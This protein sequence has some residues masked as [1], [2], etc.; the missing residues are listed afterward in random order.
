MEGITERGEAV[1]KRERERERER[2]MKMKNTTLSLLENR[3]VNGMK[4][5]QRLE[6][7]HGRERQRVRTRSGKWPRITHFKEITKMTSS[8]FMLYQ[9]AEAF[10]SLFPQGILAHD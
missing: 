10:L 8:H 5:D 9:R 2:E 6:R 3:A 4:K 7:N 1:G